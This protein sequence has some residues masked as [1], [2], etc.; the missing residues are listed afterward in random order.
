MKEGFSALLF[1]LSLTTKIVKLQY[2]AAV[3]CVSALAAVQEGYYIY[4][5]VG[6]D[7]MSG[8]WK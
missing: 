5:G 4:R 3:V 7:E 8:V 2:S 6:E 1:A